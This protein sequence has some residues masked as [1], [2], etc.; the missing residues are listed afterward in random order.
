MC[1]KTSKSSIEDSCAKM[2][3]R[4]WNPEFRNDQLLYYWERSSRSSSEIKSCVSCNELPRPRWER[5]PWACRRSSGKRTWIHPEGRWDLRWPWKGLGC[6][7]LFLRQTNKADEKQLSNDEIKAP[8][9]PTR[10]VSHGDGDAC[11]CC[12]SQVIQGAEVGHRLCEG[13]VTIDYWVLGLHW[14][15]DVC[16]HLLPLP[17]PLLRCLSLDLF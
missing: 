1:L 12:E 5:S 7:A 17:L 10:E 16:V 2:K 13:R 6:W 14:S 11:Y 15:C 9:Q 8:T 3:Y 4:K